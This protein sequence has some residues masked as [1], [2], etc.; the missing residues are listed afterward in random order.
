[1]PTRPAHATNF[2]ALWRKM[3][4]FDWWVVRACFTKPAIGRCARVLHN[5]PRCR[6]Y[7][8]GRTRRCIEVSALW[9]YEKSFERW[10]GIR[11]AG[12]GG[13]LNSLMDSLHAS[14]LRRKRVL[15]VVFVNPEDFNASQY[16]WLRRTETMRRF[17][18]HDPS[19]VVAFFIA[20]EA[21]FN[22][23]HGAVTPGLATR[24]ERAKRRATQQGRK[25]GTRRV[26]SRFEAPYGRI[27]VSASSRRTK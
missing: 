27:P 24:Q 2:S 14:L 10:Y 6:K 9:L 21:P 18:W 8:A 11:S 5:S 15:T 26:P 25:S 19:A 22:V 13:P 1:M 17:P 7:K 3:P 4:R 12:R 16:P 23:T 20:G